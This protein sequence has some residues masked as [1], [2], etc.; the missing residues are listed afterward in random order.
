MS[1]AF[2]FDLDCMDPCSFSGVDDMLAASACDV[3]A[4]GLRS[5][6]LATTSLGDAA[7]LG[8]RVCNPRVT[9]ATWG[10]RLAACSWQ[11]PDCSYVPVIGGVE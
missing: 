5:N 1:S 2:V 4:G 7:M 8:G 11:R 6:S 3:C 9:R 10:M